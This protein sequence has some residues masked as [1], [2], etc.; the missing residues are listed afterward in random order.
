MRWSEQYGLRWTQ[1]DLKRNN[2][3]LLESKSGSKQYVKITSAARRAL[4]ELR[5]RA[6]GSEFVCPNQDEWTHRQWWDAARKES[7]I[8]DFH[9]HDLRRTFAS[10]LVM[11]GVDIY[12][13]N[14]LMRH[15]TLQIT[16]RYAH[17]A[18]AHLQ[19][20]VERLRGVTRSVTPPT[21]SPSRVSAIIN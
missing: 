15:E 5:A 1:V 20:S 11:N 4:D 7:K 21:S 2:I 18:D 14:R 9:W 3:T 6:R 16:K 10:R 8:S 17:L 13:V 12:T 19:Q